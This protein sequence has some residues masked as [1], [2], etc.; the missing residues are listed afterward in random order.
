MNSITHTIEM[1]MV[2]SSRRAKEPCI[3]QV[4]LGG[5]TDPRD[6]APSFACRILLRMNRCKRHVRLH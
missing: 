2:T 4:A 6:T 5:E 3:R 1:R